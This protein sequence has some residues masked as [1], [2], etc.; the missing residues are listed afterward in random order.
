[1]TAALLVLSAVLGAGSTLP[2]VVALPGGGPVLLPR[3]G[4]VLDGTGGLLEAEPVSGLDEA[5]VS[6]WRTASGSIVIRE[7]ERGVV[8]RAYGPLAGPER[9]SRP[10]YGCAS[11][12]LP[13]GGPAGS[14]AVIAEKA[15]GPYLVVDAWSGLPQW[16]DTLPAGMPFDALFAI[17]LDTPVL[18]L[19]EGGV[20]GLP[21]GAS[22]SM[23][24]P[25]GTW[26]VTETGGKPTLYARVVGQPLAEAGWKLP[27]AFTALTLSPGRLIGFAGQPP[28]APSVIDLA[29][30]EDLHPV[31][32]WLSAPPAFPGR[33]VERSN[34]AWLEFAGVAI[35]P[36][37]GDSRVC[38]S[39]PAVWTPS[40]DGQWSAVLD[41]YRSA[42]PHAADGASASE[43]W[44]VVVP[45]GDEFEAPLR[46]PTTR[47]GACVAREPADAWPPEALRPVWSLDGALVASGAGVFDAATGARVGTLAEG[48]RPLAFLADGRLA[49]AEPVSGDEAPALRVWDRETG[50][51]TEFTL[52]KATPVS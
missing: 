12:A 45:A 13:L 42:D 31:R 39:D 49:Y 5:S 44:L 41:A 52:D 17:G 15:S 32:G 11:L 22:V 8:A 25:D 33:R 38:W 24:G 40:P 37:T 34:G 23:L 18:A 30:G 48:A 10:D 29:T 20:P 4:V 50:F 36:E 27:E 19:R 16:V 1:M 7:S 47:W 26:V 6:V 14:P 28:L 51:A 46:R 21:A 2:A 3:N 9:M 43:V 35:H